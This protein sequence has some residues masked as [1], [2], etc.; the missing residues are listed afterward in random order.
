MDWSI[1]ARG[2][3]SH[4]PAHRLYSTVGPD[5]KLDAKPTRER[6]GMDPENV[7]F[8]MLFLTGQIHALFMVTQMLANAQPEPTKV[9][10]LL[11]ALEQAGIANLES[12]PVG[13]AMLDGLRRGFSGVRGAVEAAAAGQRW[14]GSE[15]T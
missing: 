10:S 4:F 9:L 6:F 2:G 13:D 11:D 1:L 7:E 14:R 8:T 12:Q 3:S 15:Q 5:V